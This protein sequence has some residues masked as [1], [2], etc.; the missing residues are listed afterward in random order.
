MHDSIEQ[1]RQ[2]RAVLEAVIKATGSTIKGDACHCPHPDHPDRRE[3]SS[4]YTGDDGA[5][6]VKCHACGFCGDVFDLRAALQGRDVAD[7]LREARGSD[8]PQPRKITPDMLTIAKRYT[9]SITDGQL[10]ALADRLGVAADILQ[11]LRVGWCERDGAFSFPMRDAGE[12]VVRIVPH[13]AGPFQTTVHTA[14]SRST[15]S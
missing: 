3:S 11:R 2:D 7:L 12:F 1:Q 4:I 9:S 14:S 10:A 13:S 15:V 8:S 6:R 5:S